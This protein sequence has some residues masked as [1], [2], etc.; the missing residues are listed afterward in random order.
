MTITYNVNLASAAASVTGD[1]VTDGTT[2]VLSLSNI[3]DW[4]LTV[5]T[6]GYGTVDLLGPLSGN[7][8]EDFLGPNDLTATTTGLFFNFQDQTASSTL[9]FDYP[10]GSSFNTAALD[11]A[12]M[13]ANP[14]PAA[15]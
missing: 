3:V 8:S 9:Y 15:G 10:N 4:N 5:S 11:F 12:N 1:N 2:G 6:P 14:N 13:L 7:N